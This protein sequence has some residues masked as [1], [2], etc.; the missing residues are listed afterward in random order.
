MRFITSIPEM[1]LGDFKGT[2]SN[3]GNWMKMNSTSET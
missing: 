2:I 1:E 3:D